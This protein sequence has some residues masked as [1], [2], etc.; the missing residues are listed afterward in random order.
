MIN[1]LRFKSEIAKNI[2]TLI[3]GTLVAQSVTIVISPILTRIYTPEDFGIFSLYL[4]IAGF[5]S[6]IAT[7]RYEMAIV[8]S[9]SDKGAINTLTL[10]IC[11]TLF[12][13]FLTIGIISL[14]KAHITALL[15]IKESDWILYLLPISLLLAGLHQSFSHW[16]N[17]KKYFKNIASSRIFQSIGA[18]A[19]QLGFGYGVVLGGMIFG[20]M[21]GRMISIVVLVKKFFLYDRQLLK[22]IE[23]KNIIKQMK[24]H[25]DLPTINSLHVLSDTAKTS[26]STVFIS[27]FFGN[28]VLG[29]YALSFRVLQLPLS[30]IGSS[31][32]QVLYQKLSIAYDN[33]EHMYGMVK[34]I[35][36]KLFLVS[37]P[38]FGALHFLAPELFMFIFGEEW[39]VAGEYTT[40]LLPYLAI[41]FLSSPVSHIPIILGRQKTFFYINMIRN[42]GEPILIYLGYKFGLI[43]E[44]ILFIVTWF[45]V[46]FGSYL[47]FWILFIIKKYERSL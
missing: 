24:K 19:V 5:L 43:I 42:I 15:N 28:T 7:G 47:L 12:L 38:I 33:G 1:R 14:F 45:S 26:L 35:L 31:F 21:A 39:R 34:S 30:V 37:L 16:S 36:I 46:I 40:I 2:L 9:K 6:V 23:K 29:L 4:G 20:S 10:S 41:S 17:R 22:K 32:G 25:K 11:I 27:L 3:T 44:D 13:T 18:G 8:L